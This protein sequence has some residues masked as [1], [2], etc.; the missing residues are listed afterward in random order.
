MA[1]SA[2]IYTLEQERLVREEVKKLRTE[3][4]LLKTQLKSQAFK[5]E[6]KINELELIIKEQKEIIISQ[7]RIIEKLTKRVE[8]LELNQ[9]VY[10]GMIFKSQ[11]KLSS[12]KDIVRIPHK[13]SSKKIPTRIDKI[14]NTF[15]ERCP[16]CN[17]ELKT[18]NSK[19]THIVEDILLS[20]INTIVTKYNKQRQWCNH[21]QKEYVSKG[22]K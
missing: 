12:K 6:K 14:V 9:K 20:Q 7:A 2:G 5:Y 16:K 3:N 22:E 19:D 21:C 10:I 15:Y 17:S 1:V 11:S 13:G 4:T 18:T 8:E